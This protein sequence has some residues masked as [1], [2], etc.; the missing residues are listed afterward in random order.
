MGPR[1]YVTCVRPVSKSILVGWNAQKEF[2][3]DFNRRFSQRTASLI[4]EHVHVNGNL[5]WEIGVEIGQVRMKDGSTRKVGWIAISG[6]EK[7]AGQWLMVS[8]HAQPR[9]Q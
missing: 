6:Y 8:R 9:P 5:A 4:D 2:W 7:L 3:D 1:P